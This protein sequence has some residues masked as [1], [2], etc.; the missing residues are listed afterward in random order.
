MKVYPE[1][2]TAFE[3]FPLMQIETS[4]LAV[5]ILEEFVVL[6]YDCMSDITNFNDSRKYLFTQKT[7]G[8]ENLPLTQEVFKHIKTS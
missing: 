2:I 6:L 7:R 3:E 8:L 4:D 1:V 5:E